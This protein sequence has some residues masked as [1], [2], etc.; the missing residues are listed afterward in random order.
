MGQKGEE[1]EKKHVMAVAEAT[2]AAAQAAAIAAQAAAEV[3][4]LTGGGAGAGGRSRSSFSY[5]IRSREDRAALK[6]Q[7]AF[8]GYLVTRTSHHLHTTFRT[9]AVR[10]SHHHRYLH[11][12]SRIHARSP[13]DASMFVQGHVCMISRSLMMHTCMCSRVREDSCIA[14]ALYCIY[15]SMG[16][17]ICRCPFIRNCLCIHAD[18]HFIHNCLSIVHSSTSIYTYTSAHICSFTYVHTCMH[19]HMCILAFIHRCKYLH[20]FIDANTCIHSQMQSPLYEY[21]NICIHSHMQGLHG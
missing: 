2:A 10:R 18:A 16:V 20:S 5:G 3:V 8:R 19:S 6:I 7:A 21:A 17:S 1:E 12:N 4:R 15:V 13:F 14:C 11:T 9:N